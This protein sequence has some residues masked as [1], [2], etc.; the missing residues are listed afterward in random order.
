[1][2]DILYPIEKP[3]DYKFY[4]YKLVGDDVVEL[5]R[6]VACS[7]EIDDS[8]NKNQVAG[9]ELFNWCISDRGQWIMENA[10]ETPYFEYYKRA[11]RWT[12]EFKVIATFTAKKLTEYYLRFS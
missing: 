5:K 4:D 8:T 11:D 9:Q 10:F 12:V 6:I 2:S 3:K 7:F 1:M